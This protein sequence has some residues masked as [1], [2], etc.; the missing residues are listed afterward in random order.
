[1]DPARRPTL[2]DVARRAGVSLGS[3]SRAISHPEAVRA[4][5]RV[6]VE[7]AAAELGYVPNGTA[8]ALAA[9]RSMMI[10]V[11][12]PTINN[13]VFASFVHV[14]QRRLAA[15][16]YHLLVQA[17]EYDPAAEAAII[18][19]LVRKGVDGL[20]LV[21]TDHPPEVLELLERTR[22]P[23]LFS[24]ST[25][26]APAEGCIG[27]SNRG[28]MEAVAEHLLGLG[29]RRFAIL[30]GAVDH[31]ERAR[32]RIEGARRALERAGVTLGEDHVLIAPFSIEGGR[33]GLRAA[34]ALPERPTA[35]ICTTDLMAAGAVAEA[36]AV[37]LAVPADLSITG[38]DDI[39]LATVVDPPL[40]T[41]HAPI[42]RMG[43][44]VGERIVALAAGGAMQASLAI[45]AELVVRGSS[46]RPG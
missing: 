41:V 20:V 33:Q 16:G 1:M 7:A 36:R 9:G 11:V 13:P 5:T 35:L 27:F 31:N 28:A 10:G 22:L 44:L 29:H 46:A 37:G 6:A 25:D 26:E 14:L 15:D 12:L 30:S 4:K 32:A 2:E 24:W 42:A 38:F 17:H 45:P 3:A 19:R 18:A 21:G 43:E 40:T 8:R 23:H 34:L 39:D